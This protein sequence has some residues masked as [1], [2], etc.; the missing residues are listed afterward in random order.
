M[1]NWFVVCCCFWWK[2]R[3][4]SEERKKDREMETKNQSSHCWWFDSYNSAKCSPWLE[5]TLSGSF[6]SYYSFFLD[7]FEFSCLLLVQFSLSV[8]INFRG[9]N[10]FNSVKFKITFFIFF[11]IIAVYLSDLFLFMIKNN[12]QYICR[13]FLVNS[14]W[15]YISLINVKNLCLCH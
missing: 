2:L 14:H 4:K 8:I 12:N 11:V 13:K 7:L 5:S 10:Y 6:F 15:N 1:L 9:R 3:E